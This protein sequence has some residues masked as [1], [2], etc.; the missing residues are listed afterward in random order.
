[1]NRLRSFLIGRNGP[2]QLSRA[3]TL[4]A[5]VL[6]ILSMLFRGMISSILWALA[7]LF[8]VVSYWR[9]FSRNIEKRRQENQQF[10]T[11]IAPLSRKWNQ[12]KL[13][14]RQRNIYSFFKCPSCG[15][16]LRVPK[17]KGHVR[18]TCKSCGN[19]FERNS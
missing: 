16:V 7:L 3:I 19:V 5:C 8:L 1:M 14:R 9:I 12:W 6:L 4:L 15:T 17:G 11:R 18:I 10:L 13:R 2:D